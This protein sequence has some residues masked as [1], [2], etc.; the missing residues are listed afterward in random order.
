MFHGKTLEIQYE[1]EAVY[2]PGLVLQGIESRPKRHLHHLVT[3]EQLGIR[4]VGP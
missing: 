4:R 2:L 1:D 3:T